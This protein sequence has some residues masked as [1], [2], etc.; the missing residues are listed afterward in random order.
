M[1]LDRHFA[2]L[3]IGGMGRAA[4]MSLD[5]ILNQKPKLICCLAD[6]KGKDWVSANSRGFPICFH[7]P[8]SNHQYAAADDFELGH[9]QTFG[10]ESFVRLTPYKWDLIA[11]SLRGHPESKG[12]MFSDLDVYWFK[13]YEQEDFGFSSVNDHVF[14]QKDFFRY[15][16]KKH[17]C[18][19][20]M[21]WPNRAENV[22]LL[23]EMSTAHKDLIFQGNL[24]PDEPFFNEYL[25][26]QKNDNKVTELSEKQYVIGHKL[27]KLLLTK[28]FSTKGI[29][30]F[31]A[32]YLYGDKEK[33]IALLSMK[34]KYSGGYFWVLGFVYISIQ[35]ALRKLGLRDV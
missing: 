19:G 14:A 30:A 29:S 6:K 4:R 8:E 9:L 5:G 17:F 28:R 26:V 16:Q 13:C 3:A 15:S 1:S 10:Q 18:T 7:S 35:K 2:I 11:S 20:I 31:H 34:S 21:Y 33:F 23:R 12:V 27:L 24:V 32:N 25:G 22:A